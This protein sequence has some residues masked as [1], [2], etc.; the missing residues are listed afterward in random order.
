MRRRMTTSPAWRV[1]LRRLSSHD[2]VALWIIL[3]VSRPTHLNVHARAH[4]RFHF[5]FSSPMSDKVRDYKEGRRG[6]EERQGHF[7]MMGLRLVYQ[8]IDSHS[9]DR[10]KCRCRLL[11]SLSPPRPYVV[12]TF[13]WFKAFYFCVC[14]PSPY[15]ILHCANRGFHTEWSCGGRRSDQTG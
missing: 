15:V 9:K 12:L 10:R 8:S 3:T 7:R 14:L 4:G 6:A 1:C 5:A 13:H 11:V 2:G